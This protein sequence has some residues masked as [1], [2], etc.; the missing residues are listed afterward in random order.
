MSRSEIG[1][2]VIPSVSVSVME[3]HDWML[4]DGA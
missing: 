4:Y 2:G 3:Q 1:L